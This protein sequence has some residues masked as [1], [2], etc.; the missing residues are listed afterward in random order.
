MSWVDHHSKSEKLASEA[1]SA[2]KQGDMDKALDYY[3]LAAKEEELALS[4]LD[5]TKKRTLGITV[6]S[7]ASLYFKGEEFQKAE[8]IAHQY[9]ASE[10]LPSF[11]IEQLQSILRAV[12]N[13]KTFKEAGI[14]FVKGEVLVSVEGGII[15]PGGAPLDLIHRKIDEIKNVFFR[16]IEMDLGLPLRKKGP[17]S[18]EIQTNYRPWLLQRAPGSYQFAIR[19]EKPKQLSLFSS[20]TPS[21]EEVTQKFFE[22]I[23]ATAQDPNEQLINLVPNPEYRKSFL[24]LTRNLAPTGKSFT[25]LEIKS[26]A[27][28]EAPPIVFV[29]ESRK[30][31]NDVLKSTRKPVEKKDQLKETQLK[32]VLRGLQLDKDW[33]EINI[34][35][36]NETI[37]VYQTGDVIDDIVGP[38]VNHTVIVEVVKKGGKYTYRDIE[39]EE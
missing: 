6:I 35:E 11:A 15:V 31:I 13:E 18:N 36:R 38:M 16:V 25:R 28:M 20:G 14:K 34:S 37:R 29:P 22:V 10:N 24:T 23:G 27:D 9:L 8:K 5:I 30:S 1:Q 17:P 19:V 2:R 3:N 33:I 7:A 39:I 21:I 12:W 32:G 26:T 4:S